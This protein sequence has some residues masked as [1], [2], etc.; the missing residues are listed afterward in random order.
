[1][2]TVTPSSS[3]SSSLSRDGN[4]IVLIQSD[5]LEPLC[6]DGCESLVGAAEAG[7]ISVFV[8]TTRNTFKGKK[9][10][11]L[12]YEAYEPMALKQMRELCN[13][14]RQRW[15]NV[16]KCAILH[17]TGVVAVGEASVVI[18]VSSP[19]RREALESVA[20]CIDELKSRV[21]IWKKELYEDGSSWKEN[22][23]WDPATLTKTRREEE[24]AN[25][26]A[27]EEEKRKHT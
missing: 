2:P 6:G 27:T 15:P 4:D 1:M 12:E 20:W 9:V 14:M 18:A 5:A 19:H 10:L 25:R 24:E 23:E 21:A 11:R 13:E 3:S 26:R 8:G 22:A 17:R 16:V 7:A